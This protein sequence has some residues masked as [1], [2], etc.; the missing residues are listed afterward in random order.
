MRRIGVLLAGVLA[1]G[2]IA[3]VP[4]TAQGAPDGSG[5]VIDEVYLNGGSAG[6]THRNKFVELRNPTDEEV[7]VSGW[8]VQYRSYSSTSRFTGVIPLG[9]HTI[10]PGGTLLVSGNSNAANGADLPTPDVESN[11][12][13][14][15]NDNGGTL[16]LV[17]SSTALTGDR[18]AVLGDEDLVDLVGYGVSATFEGSAPTAS[19]YSVTS[20]LARTDAADTDDN[21]A[22]LAAADPTP[23]PCGAACDGSGPVDPVDPEPRSIEQVQGTGPD[24]PDVGELVELSGVV[25]AAYPS[26]GFDGAY[27]QTAGT[28]DVDLDDH[29]ASHGIFVSSAALGSEVEVGDHVQ[30]VGTVEEHFGL[31]RVVASEHRTLDEP[32]EAV[33]PSQVDFPLTEDERESLEG[34]LLAPHGDFTVTNNYTTNQFGEIGLAAGATPLAQPTD[35]ARPGSEEYDAVVAENARRLVTLDD[36]R[37]TSFT[38][39]AGQGLP[40]S[41]LRPDN[42]VRVGAPAQVTEPV[43]LDFRFD[44][45]RL[46]P[47]APLQADAEPATFGSTREAAPADVGGDVTIAAFNVLNYFTT[48]GETYESNGLGTCTYYTDRAGERT[49]V[50]RCSGTG[51]RGAADDTNLQRQEDK[52]VEAINALEVDVVS[53]QEIENSA[54]FG[55]D[56][57]TALRALVAALNEDA[58]RERWAAVES[59]AAVPEGEDVIRTAFIHDADSVEPVGVSVIDD[60]PAFDNARDPLAQEFRPVGGDE[61]DDFLVIVNHF[62][63]KG[64]GEGEDADQGDGQGG[65]NASRVRQATALTELAAEQ[66]ERARTDMVF[67]T[68]DF[69][70][71]SREDPV[72]VIED[73]GFVNVP[74]AFDAPYTY[75][76]DGLVGSLDH[77]FASEAA[78]DRVT[79]ADV[80]GINAAESVGREYSRFNANATPLYDATPFRASDHD[81]AV[82]G[83]DT[84][85]ATEPPDGPAASS[86]EVVGARPGILGRLDVEVTTEGRTVDGG[87]VL[88]KRGFW[89]VGLGLVDDGTARVLVAG[90]QRGR[91][92]TLTYSGD[93]DTRASSTTYRVP[94]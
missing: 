82:V 86:V 73:A 58:G 6:A 16:A 79:G 87:L 70:S 34:M 44:L 56:R 47:T 25:T 83:F 75:Q 31:T 23:T 64:S 15:G 51:P 90:L 76:F 28:G 40:V 60:D 57:D 42:E 32:A 49:T 19:G 94:R 30:V 52:I 18:A 43:V 93:R 54:A 88:V 3:A 39:G 7:D 12:A 65:S 21:A 78:F 20:S 36:G 26:G 72:E 74:K 35:V 1:A 68:G 59:P 10:Q 37:S 46:Q 41:W 62:K 2:T 11:V 85:T 14:S 80:W 17:R 8:S 55:I 63:S 27:L 84:T 66:S 50:N 48:T 89:P 71:Y 67:L 22:D 5:V 9:E 38:S 81:P 53:L 33:K 69:N 61:D 13:F 92:Y 45:W 24:S 91:E 29:E 77:V 4:G